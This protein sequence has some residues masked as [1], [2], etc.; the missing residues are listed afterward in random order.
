MMRPTNDHRPN[1]FDQSCWASLSLIEQMGNISSEV[2]RAFN[3]IRTNKPDRAQGAFFRG[4]D[5][6]NATIQGLAERKS[7]RLKEVLLA[8]DQFAN[9]FLS[10]KV[11]VGLENYFN[12]FAVLARVDR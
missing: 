4:I 3:G 6:L 10:Q 12:Y 1:H 11:D 9:S 2:G 7:P 8:R 5:L